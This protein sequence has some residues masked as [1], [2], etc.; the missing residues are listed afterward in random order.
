MHGDS[1]H[2]NRDKGMHPLRPR[3]GRAMG[4][5]TPF[6]GLADLGGLGESKL[7]S[8]WR[9]VYS[10]DELLQ[11]Y[12][13]FSSREDAENFV[14]MALEVGFPEASE[15]VVSAEVANPQVLGRTLE[16]LRP[17]HRDEIPLGTYVR[18]NP[19]NTTHTPDEEMTW[20][21]LLSGSVNEPPSR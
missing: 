7:L 10:G 8:G 14:K 17:I 2:A 16:H 3:D 20:G 9:V 11:I 15:A 13:V 6:W 5:Q 21:R 4:P 19:D 18:L 1:E 12:P